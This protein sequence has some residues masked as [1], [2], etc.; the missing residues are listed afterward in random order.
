[1]TLITP[2][3]DEARADELMLSVEDS[4]GELRHQ[5]KDLTKKI[6]AGEEVKATDVKATLK[7]LPSTLATFLKLEVQLAEIRRTRSQVAQGGY[8]LDL[9][10]AKAEVRCALGRLRSCCGAGEISG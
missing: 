3:D 5:I 4:L 1:M 7:D 6:D 9:D 10:F 8:A 2:G